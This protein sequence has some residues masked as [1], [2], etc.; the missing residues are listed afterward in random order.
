MDRQIF[1]VEQAAE[2]LG[3]PRRTMYQWLKRGLLPYFALTENRT[4][5]TLEHVERISSVL[6]NDGRHGVLQGA[7]VA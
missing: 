4:L 1:T 2:T 7:C 5:L 3:I 6:E